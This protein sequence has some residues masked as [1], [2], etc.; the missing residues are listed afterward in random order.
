MD[1]VKPTVTE[2]TSSVNNDIDPKSKEVAECAICGK[3]GTCLLCRKKKRKNSG[4]I[5]FKQKKGQPEITIT[6]D[7]EK[8]PNDE[9]DFS[10]ESID[11]EDYVEYTKAEEFKDETEPTKEEPEIEEEVS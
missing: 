3:D 4:K 2:S 9:V 5:L 7:S 8:S 1:D 10:F 6:D 11:E